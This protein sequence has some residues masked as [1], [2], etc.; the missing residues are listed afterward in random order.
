MVV[1]FDLA[2]DQRGVRDVADGDEDP[3]HQLHAVL[4]GHRV[5]NLEPH[6]LVVAED[7]GD[8]GV[9]LEADLL[10]R[11]GPFLHDL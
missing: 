7:L 5:A 6:D 1:Q 4:A 9:P 3:G 10:V 11:E 2:G 8:L